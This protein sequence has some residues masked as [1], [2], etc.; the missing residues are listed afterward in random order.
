MPLV[1]GGVSQLAP[2]WDNPPVES[3]EP[4]LTGRCGCLLTTH[5]KAKLDSDDLAHAPNDG[6]RYELLDGELFVTPSSSPLHQRVSNACNLAA[7]WR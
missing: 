1:P 4:T 6:Q 2:P 5:L 3:C 7:L